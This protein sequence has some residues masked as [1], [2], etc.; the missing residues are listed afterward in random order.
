[1]RS[2]G[3]S[4]SSPVREEPT[5][6]EEILNLLRLADRDLEQAQVPGLYPDGRFSFAYNAALQLA[7]AYLRLH[8]LR[9]GSV[10]RHARTFQELQQRIPFDMRHYPQSFE[11]ARR[12][13]HTLVYD[14]VGA[15]SE[16]EVQDLLGQ[17]KTF[18]AWLCAEIEQRFPQYKPV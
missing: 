11:R 4:D 14:Q 10:G 2:I 5:S 15:V 8:H 9:I 3:S 7:T 12:R 17:V 6:R 18:R 16:H 13:R 1:M